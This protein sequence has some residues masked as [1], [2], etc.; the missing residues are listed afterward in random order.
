MIGVATRK[1][2]EQ[3]AQATAD[4]TRRR[5]ARR[6]WAR[7]WRAWRYVAASVLLV[8]LVVGGGWLFWFS[9]VFTVTQVGVQ[10]E[11]HL[12]ERQVLAAAQVPDGGHLASLDLA[13]IA[14]RVRALAP[15]R[16]VDVERHWPH[17]VAITITERTPV[18]V[19][20]IGGQ[21]RGMDA[22]GVVF[23]GYRTAPPG[24]PRVESSADANGAALAEAAKV[25]GAMPAGLLTRVDHVS[26]GSV[27]A[28]SLVM[29]GGATV[30]WGSAE[31]SA[32]KAKVLV[33]LLHQ[34][35]RGYDVSVPSQPTVRH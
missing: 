10:G 25:V 18:A 19:V 32:E 13:A 12:S 27:D 22:G 20:S 29:R 33:A 31:Q 11:H 1:D 7:R 14:T 15:V 2:P 30:L 35:G 9:S 3:R 21:L 5:F 17:G 23:R 4:R 16:S 6:Q 24:L 34:P 26:V 28:I 8:A